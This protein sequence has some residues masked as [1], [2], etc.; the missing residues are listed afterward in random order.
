VAVDG[1]E[2]PT[3]HMMNR[4]SKPI[5]AFAV[6]LALIC[7]TVSINGY[8]MVIQYGWLFWLAPILLV[9]GLLSLKRC[10]VLAFVLYSV[11][12]ITIGVAG[13]LIGDWSR[14]AYCFNKCRACEPML[15]QLSAFQSCHGGS[16]TNL[17]PL[18]MPKGITVQQRILSGDG[19]NLDDVNQTDAT[20]Y[21]GTSSFICVVPVTKILPM[22]FTRFYAYFRNE[23][24]RNWKYDYSVWTLGGF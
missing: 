11:L 18:V 13:M 15:E 8:G 20:L 14:R 7:F 6:A 2:E 24:D 12:V 17:P 23:K 22:S 5:V 16:L 21:L 3:K 4:P 1:Q 9:V 10:G 19:L